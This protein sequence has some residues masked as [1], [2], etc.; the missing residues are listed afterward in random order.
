MTKTEKLLAGAK[1]GDP[2]AQNELGNLYWDSRPPDKRKAVRW[3]RLAA[4]QGH[5]SAQF[6]LGSALMM[7]EGVRRDRATAVEWFR[8]AAE[9]GHIGAQCNM[10]RVYDGGEGATPDPKEAARWY[11]MVAERG[12][13]DAQ[14]HL[15]YL[16]N[17]SSD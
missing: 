4:D 2:E 5:A 7:G 6:N 11:R 12:D 17:G 15:A 16:L 3:F 14:F 8:R 10:G 1:A 13:V 9:Q